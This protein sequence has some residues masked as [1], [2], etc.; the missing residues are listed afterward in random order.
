[1]EVP[2]QDILLVDDS[3]NDVELTLLGLN[4][5]KLANTIV[6]ARDGVEAL[7][8]LYCRRTHSTRPARRPLFVL[9]DLKM[10]R[11]DGLEVLE[12]VRADKTFDTMPIVVMTSSRESPDVARSY[13]LGAN[14]YVV[15]PVGYD[16]FTEAVKQLGLFWAILN[17]PASSD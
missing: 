6:V 17:E 9:L 8:Y 10:P 3:E 16:G 14:A 5:L 12:E 7:D 4:A 11:V 2:L 15:K 1:M 13:E